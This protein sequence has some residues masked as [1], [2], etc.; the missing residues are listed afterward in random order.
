MLKMERALLSCCRETLVVGVRVWNHGL[1][2]SFAR[3]AS[4]GQG[5]RARGWV[6][7]SRRAQA[8]LHPCDAGCPGQLLSDFPR[9]LLEKTPTSA[10]HFCS[11]S[12]LLGCYS[13]TLLMAGSFLRLR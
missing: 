9:A 11:P 8:A 13:W 4:G 6:P 5:G 7:A 10:L 12:S 3:D 2:P 1:S